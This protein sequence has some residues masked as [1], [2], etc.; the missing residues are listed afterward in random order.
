MLSERLKARFAPLESE[1]L[2]LPIVP[3][4]LPLPTCKRPAETEIVPMPEASPDN[5]SVPEP[6]LVN[7]P[8]P[9]IV[10]A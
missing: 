1:T 6:A 5:E 8:A 10:P 7:P 2:S 4:V 3:V 9:L